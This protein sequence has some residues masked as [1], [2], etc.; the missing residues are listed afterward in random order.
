MCVGVC[1]ALIQVIHSTVGSI[2][3]TD[4]QYA[5]AYECPVY[6]FRVKRPLRHE[7]DAIDRYGVRALYYAHHQHLIDEIERNMVV[8]Y[9][10]RKERTVEAARRVAEKGKAVEWKGHGADRE[11]EGEEGEDAVASGGEDAE[12][13]DEEREEWERFIEPSQ[14]P[15]EQQQQQADGQRL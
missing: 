4:I 13:E 5:Q 12:D 1:A 6:C 10:R 14:L 3:K 2:T 11:E 15:G 8:E 9:E 7:Q